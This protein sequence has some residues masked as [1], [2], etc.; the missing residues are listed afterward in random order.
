MAFDTLIL[1]GTIVDGTNTPRYKGD[2]GIS[3]GRIE[4]IGTLNDAEAKRRIDA[5]GHVVSPGFIDMH[6]HSDVTLFD[7]PGGESKAHQGVTTEVTGN[8]SLSPFPAGRGGPKALQDNLGTNLIGHIDW[9]W[10]TLDDWAGAL[11]SSGISI[12]IAPQLGQAALQVAVGAIDD[13]PVTRDEMREMQSLAAEAIEMGA[14]SLSTGLSI[15]PSGYATT[16]DVVALCKTINEF[17]GAFYVTHARVGNGKHLSSIEEAI[18]IG[19][20][21]EIPVQFSHMAIIDRR[22]FGAG[23]AMVDLMVKAR[24]GG[25]DIT[26]DVYPYTAAGAGFNQLIPLWVQEGTIADFVGRVRD[27]QL[28]PR[29]RA[30]VAAGIGGLEPLWDAWYV[31]YIRT[32][33]NRHF[34]GRN[35]VEIAREREVEPAEAVLQLLEEEDTFVPTRVHNRLEDDVRYFVGHDLA[36]IGSDGQ[37]VAPNGPFGKSLP[38]PRFYGTYPRILGKYVRDEPVL[39]LE[40]AVYKMSGFPAQR[41]SMKDRGL[42]KEG[43]VADLVVFDPETVIDNATWEDPHQYPDGMPYVL[44][45]GVPI[46]DQGKHTGARPGRVLRRG[47]S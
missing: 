33:A 32:E 43:L 24:E 36:M 15:A 9:A 35:I 11:E 6:S 29:I 21:G 5:S 8:C 38:H 46:V 34:V 16:D 45:N 13:R 10:N 23:P 27:S 25:L 42:A 14:F 37:A 30:E 31:A 44:V 17:D 2:V 20:R 41:M 26:Y 4:A 1:N 47:A 18:E 19:Q 40:S 22:V 28:R 7:D 12:N 39:S 3:N